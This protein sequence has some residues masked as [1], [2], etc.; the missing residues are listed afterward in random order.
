MKYK[1]ILFNV[2]RTSRCS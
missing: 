2:C 1:P